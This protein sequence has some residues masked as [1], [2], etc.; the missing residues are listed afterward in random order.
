MTSSGKERRNACALQL[1]AF[2]NI[3]GKNTESEKGKNTEYEKGKNTEC[4]S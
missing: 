3:K 2:I 4:E 1:D